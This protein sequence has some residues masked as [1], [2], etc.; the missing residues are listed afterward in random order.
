MLK[1]PSQKELS[2]LLNTL[3]ERFEANLK[4]H[5]TTSW[6]VVEEHLSKNTKV[7]SS[8]Y[9]LEA[10]GGEPDVVEL[11][12]SKLDV[13]FMDC[14]KETPEGRRSLCYDHRKLVQGRL[15]ELKFYCKVDLL[16]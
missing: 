11:S 9:Q 16:A 4:R 15:T 5:K 12:S 3:K 1:K 8:I 7:L 10:S 13:F 6:K 2:F 14:S